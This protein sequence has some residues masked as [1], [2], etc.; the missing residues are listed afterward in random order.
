MTI[1]HWGAATYEAQQAAAWAKFGR[2]IRRWRTQNGWTQYLGERIQKELSIPSLSPSNWS[3][4]ESGKA[5]Q[6][7]PTTFYKLAE[8]NSRI[9]HDDW[10]PIH[11]RELKDWLTAPKKAI[12]NAAGNPW[13]PNEFWGC[14]TGQ[15]ASPDWLDDRVAPE[16]SDEQAA[17]LCAAWADEFRALK[18]EHKVPTRAALEGLCQHAPPAERDFLSDVCSGDAVYSAE[19]LRAGWDRD[20]LPAKALHDWRMQDLHNQADTK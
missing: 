18:L 13:G 3:T 15:L 19:Q 14:A 5:G 9:F 10:P 17:A 8:I 7:K 1:N 12:V 6:M 11:S 16:I 2:M 4:I 20:W